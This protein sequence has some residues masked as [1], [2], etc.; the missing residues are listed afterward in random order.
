MHDESR[1]R[2]DGYFFLRMPQGLLMSIPIVPVFQHAFTDKSIESQFLPAFKQYREFADVA[3]F[4]EQGGK[5]LLS[6]DL[7]A[8]HV[9]CI[10][11]PLEG[12]SGTRLGSN[13]GQSNG[14]A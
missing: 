3:V 2:V 7:S 8:F 4:R 9:Q 12:E 10:L 11:I 6:V 14:H 13:S 1:D 5:D